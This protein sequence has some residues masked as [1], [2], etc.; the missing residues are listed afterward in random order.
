MQFRVVMNDGTDHLCTTAEGESFSDV[1]SR[2]AEV[3]ADGFVTFDDRVSYPKSSIVK[4]EKVK[5]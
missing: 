5:D 1:V 3:R 2:H 4:I